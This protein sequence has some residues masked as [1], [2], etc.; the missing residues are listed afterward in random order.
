MTQIIDIHTSISSAL[1][2]EIVGKIGE[3][4][5]Q[6]Y[7]EKK[8][9]QKG[10]KI[11]FSPKKSK[12]YDPPTKTINLLDKI[13]N[14]FKQSNTITTEDENSRLSLVF[15]DNSLYEELQKLGII[16]KTN[17]TDRKSA[18]ENEKSTHTRFS[19]RALKLL[20][21]AIEL[22]NYTALN[23]TQIEKLNKLLSRFNYHSIAQL[24][25][26]IEKLKRE[27]A[28]LRIHP[29]YVDSLKAVRTL[30][31]PLIDKLKPLM[32]AYLHTQN[33]RKKY[34]LNPDTIVLIDTGEIH[35]YESKGN[36]GRFTNNQKIFLH[37]KQD[38]IKIY[39][40]NIA[41]EM[42]KTIQIKETKIN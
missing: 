26:D 5:T 31:Q 7:I 40:I 39:L 6:K 22:T 1:K 27:A 15:F 38:K 23:P 37:E 14:I 30:N 32:N 41:I 42:P 12:K 10:A 34:G 28:I 3:Q 29:K 24:G 8:Y 4:T 16:F 19:E 2:A 35:M 11:V 25:I 13:K 33:I 9:E 20:F 17:Y 18:E 21:T 36:K